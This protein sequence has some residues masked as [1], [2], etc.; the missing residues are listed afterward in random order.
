MW[1]DRDI[2]SCRLMGGNVVMRE[3]VCGVYDILAAAAS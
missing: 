1:V 3:K 2:D